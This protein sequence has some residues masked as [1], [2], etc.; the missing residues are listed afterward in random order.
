ML[1]VRSTATE[2]EAR[3]ARLGRTVEASWWLRGAMQR[4]V[5]PR[6]EPTDDRR[7]PSRFAAF[8]RRRALSAG[9]Q[10]DSASVEGP[11]TDGES[12]EPSVPALV[13]GL[14][15]PGKEYGETRHNVGARCVALLARRHGARLERHGR[16]D[17][18]TISVGGRELHLARPRAYMNESGPPVAAEARRLGLRRP[19]L[20]MVY[21]EL[22]LP[23]G[24]VRLRLGGGYGGNRGMKSVITSLGGNDIPRVRV[25]I[26]RPY[27]DGTPVRDPDR[28][29]NWVL[30]RPS[31]AER[32]VL[33]A[34]IELAADAVEFAAAE[35]VGAA[36]RRFNAADG[37]PPALRGAPPARD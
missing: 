17:R 37:S 21:D 1:Q 32:A 6:Q 11:A 26:D 31:P 16:V 29:A 25:G 22:D 35:G 18:A 12:N 20:L 8:R 34:A 5:A 36:M 19:Q 30:T 13:V 4:R 27:D 15:N 14:G 33:D 23:T 7:M 9:A 3:P 10:P 24:R 2:P 28:V